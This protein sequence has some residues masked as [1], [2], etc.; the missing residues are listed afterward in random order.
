MFLAIFIS[1]VH[2]TKRRRQVRGLKSMGIMWIVHWM[3][4][5]RWFSTGA[6]ESRQGVLQVQGSSLDQLVHAIILSFILAGLGLFFVQQ[7][8]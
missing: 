5:S 3:R 2:R 8:G 1:S 6:V 4:G 7:L